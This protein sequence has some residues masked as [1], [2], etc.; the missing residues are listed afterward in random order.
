MSRVTK[1]KPCWKRSWL[2]RLLVCC[3][4]GGVGCS[5]VPRRQADGTPVKAEAGRVQT[6]VHDLRSLDARVDVHEAQALADTALNHSLD[7]AEEYRAVRPAF[8]HN[9]M[10]NLKF[11]D[12][13]LCYHWADDL[14]QKLQALGP[15]T[16]RF[17]RVVSK[18]ATPHE[19][20]AVVVAGQ[21]QR[22]RQ[23]LILD[24]WRH[25]GRLYWKPVVEDSKYDWQLRQD[26]PWLPPQIEPDGPANNPPR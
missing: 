9:I 11:R 14:L 19:H 6:L 5:T 26:L 12:R 21:D 20:N 18:V 24:A 3:V 13:G 7:L 16:L 4:V 8:V 25:G 17:Y 10:V 22:M 15:R 2:A 23:G 1:P